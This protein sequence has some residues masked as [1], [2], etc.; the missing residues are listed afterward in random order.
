MP[1][2]IEVIIRTIVSFS[3][4]LIGARFLGKQTI[5]QMTI[6]DFIAAI[7]LGAITASLAY[8]TTL[9]PHTLIL[10][11]IIF[12][13]VI[14]FNCCYIHQKPKTQKVFCWKPYGCHPKWKD[15]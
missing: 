3:L 15:P 7:T 14:F 2:H 11:F 8:N 10:S 1:E 4:L 5:S 9:K 12:V 6:F 13:L